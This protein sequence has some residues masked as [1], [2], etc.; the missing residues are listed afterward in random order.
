MF[1]LLLTDIVLGLL[2]TLNDSEAAV[3]SLMHKSLLQIGDNEPVLVL[4]KSLGFLNKLS[5]SQKGHRVLVMNMMS[6]CL[7]KNVE[8]KLPDD[9]A[10]GLVIMSVLEI[11]AEKVCFLLFFLNISLKAF[12]VPKAIVCVKAVIDD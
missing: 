8:L 9:L 3:R 11:V 10:T 1:F 12:H 4:S 7:D 2:N 5:K 6:E